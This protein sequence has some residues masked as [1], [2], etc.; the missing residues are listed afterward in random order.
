MEE[1]HRR[2]LEKFVNLYKNDP[3]ILA[4][5]LGGSVAHG[6]A[7]AT[8][9]LDVM[10][11]VAEAEYQR[12]KDQN[13]LAFSLWD[14]CDYPGGY[15]DCKV[16]SPGFLDAV[17]MRGSDPARYAFLDSM[18]L[19]SRLDNLPQILEE[20]TRFPVQE[21][22]TRR[23]RFAAQLLAWK[24]YY[25]EGIKKEN[26][27]LIYLSIQKIVLFACRLVLNE[28]H[29]LYPYHKW[30]LRVV[31]EARQKPENFDAALERLL[32]SHSLDYVNQFSA[33]VLRF[34]GL[35][36]KDVDWPNRFMADSEWNWMEHE[37]PIDDL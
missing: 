10:L 34:A 3:L 21:K 13:K 22:E 35:E 4:V 36:E 24:W 19:F 18:I 16:I 25:S 15:V 37:A 14:I 23:E 8:S 17:R 33:E 1:H 2:A 31:K 9:D 27:Y 5:L 28:N 11:I 26:Q 6:F 20:I 7:T 12:R 32:S 30:L 29:L